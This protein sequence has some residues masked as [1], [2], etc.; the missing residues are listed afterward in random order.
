MIVKKLMQNELLIK[1]IMTMFVQGAGQLT[2]FISAVLLARYFSV[3]QYGQYMFGVTAATITAVIATLGADGILAR[4]WGWSDKSGSARMTEVFFIHNWFWRK[5]MFILSVFI[6]LCLIGIFMVDPHPD[7]I[8]VFAFLFAFPF[9]IA[10]L[11]QSFYIANRKVVKANLIQL[12]MR[13][14]ML[15]IVVVFLSLP[16]FRSWPSLLVSVMFFAIL[17]YMIVLWLNVSSHYGFKIKQPTGRNL[18]FML[19]K[20]GNLLLSQIDIVLLKLFSNNQSIAYYAVAL[21]LSALVVFVLNAVSANILAQVAHDYKK[22]SHHDFQCKITEYTRVIFSLS[23]VVIVALISTGYWIALLYGRTYTEAYSLFCVLMIGQVINVLC[24]SVFTILNM[25]GHEKTTCRVFYVALLINV[26]FGIS[27]IPFWHA[28][29]VAVASVI[30]MAFW[31]I[32]LLAIVL[33]RLKINPT[34][35]TRRKAAA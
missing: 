1:S 6:V 33:Q 14:I 32:T 27:L 15:V 30:A 35:F 4:S 9:L 10:N 31:N 2:A 28:Y 26:V 19:L 7:L 13:I 17:I 29:G 34:I 20:W 23:F 11:L 21:Q 24:G 3:S 12:F 16:L 5:G 25:S 18:P 8:E 22:L